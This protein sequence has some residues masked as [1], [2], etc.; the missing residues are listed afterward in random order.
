MR[1]EGGVGGR[2]DG[3]VSVGGG[4]REGQGWQDSA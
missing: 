1:L 2:E 4:N 3:S